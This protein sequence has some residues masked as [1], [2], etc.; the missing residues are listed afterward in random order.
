M[1]LLRDSSPENKSPKTPVKR[2]AQSR[3]PEREKSKGH[4]PR[5]DTPKK[6]FKKKRIQCRNMGCSD[7]FVNSN[8]R[9]RHELFRCKFRPSVDTSPGSKKQSFDVPSHSALNLK[10]NVCRFPGCG[11]VFA[12]IGSRKRHETD[13]HG[14]TET[15][16][17][18]S[19]PSIFSSGSNSP[20]VSGA[21]YQ[22]PQS[23]PPHLSGFS[24]H[25]SQGL[26]S[27]SGNMSPES[28]VDLSW[29]PNI[30]LT[31]PSSSPMPRSLFTA[32]DPEK[33]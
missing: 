10:E 16:G 14:Y 9:E 15:K 6:T 7:G 21:V 30:S 20:E 24:T 23:C 32:P 27:R 3:S 33:K 13:Q 5:K 4:T 25:T 28:D 12:Q 22:R 2:R 18:T 29:S 26:R 1:E 19:S 11:R 8:A 31:P 17:R